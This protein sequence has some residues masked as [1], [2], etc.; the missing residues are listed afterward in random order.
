MV[1]RDIL[2]QRFTRLVVT[3][4]RPS[5]RDS[6]G[7]SVAIWH[8][9]C[10]CGNEKDVTAGALLSGDTKSCGC[11]NREQQRKSKH[12]FTCTY[13]L[14]GEY[15]VGYTN[16]GDEF[17]FDKEDYELIKNYSWYKHRKYFE[18]KVPKTK[19]V[20]YLHRLVMGIGFV[21]YDHTTDVD[22]I[23]TQNKFDNRKSNLRIV[24][25]AQNN[26]NHIIQK[27]NTS[28]YSGVMYHKRDKIWEAYITI[29]RKKTYLGRFKN[30]NDA[31]NC[32]LEAENKYYGIYSYNN[33]QKI[34]VGG[35]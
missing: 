26:Q 7:R 31:I 1:K 12:R 16:K 11:L 24:N 9:K 13:D 21:A 35:N 5:I 25:K 32:R 6:K 4:P 23:I 8:V 2:G 22:H 29:N 10:D 33:S 15:G 18:A 17:W 34:N 19:K 3:E 28:G 20:I 14:S 30:K 27:N